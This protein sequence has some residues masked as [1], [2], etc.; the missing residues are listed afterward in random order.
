MFQKERHIVSCS[1]STKCIKPEKI[2]YIVNNT[3]PSKIITGIIKG[4][5]ESI[6][7]M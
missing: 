7:I 6:L 1:F 2:K 3:S 5:L 4:I